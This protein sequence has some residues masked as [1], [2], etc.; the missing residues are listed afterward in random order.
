MFPLE[1]W[2]L[3]F[4]ELDFKSKLLFISSCKYFRKN[5]FID[6]LYDID[7]MYLKKLTDEILKYSIFSHAVCLD[8][9]N[10]KKITDV[11]A[12]TSLKKL[13]AWGN[14]GIDQKGIEGLQLVE[15]NVNSNEKITD[16][17]MMTSLK[18]LDAR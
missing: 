7:Y 13:G 17:S 1:I 3:I 6:N 11:S 10:N 5:I 18:K 15:L 16:V 4:N 2:K 8:A 9:G 14:S 12:M